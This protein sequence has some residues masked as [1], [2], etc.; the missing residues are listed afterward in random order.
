MGL[1]RIR[2]AFF[3]LERSQILFLSLFCIKV[4]AEEISNFSP[5]PWTNPFAKMPI[6]CVLETDVFVV[7]KRFFAI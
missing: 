7:Q 3:S 4:N 2:E 5:K 6:F 1:Q